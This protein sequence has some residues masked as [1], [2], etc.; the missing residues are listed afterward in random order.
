MLVKVFSSSLLFVQ[1]NYMNISGISTLSTAESFDL[2]RDDMSVSESLSEERLF[3]TPVNLNHEFVENTKPVLNP[4]NT[5][6]SSVSTVAG[7]ATSIVSSVAA[8][9]AGNEVLESKLIQVLMSINLY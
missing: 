8:T 6:V 5:T 9:T 4:A 2:N 1:H 7:S 3:S